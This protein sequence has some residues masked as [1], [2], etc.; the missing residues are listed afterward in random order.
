MR[1]IF[2]C[3]LFAFALSTS[4]QKIRFTDPSNGWVTHGSAP[5]CEFIGSYFYGADTIHH[6]IRYKKIISLFTSLLPTGC[7]TDDSSWWVRED[8]LLNRVYYRWMSWGSYD[9]VEHVLFEYNLS[10]GDT[11]RYISAFFPGFKDSVKRVDSVFIN[12]YAH[13]A[14]QINNWYDAREY[15]VVEGIGCLSGPLYTPRRTC[16]EFG[17]ELMCF[18]NRGTKPDFLVD[19]NGCWAADSFN[20]ISSCIKLSVANVSPGKEVNVYPNPAYETLNVSI[21]GYTD[22]PLS[23]VISDLLGHAVLRSDIQKNGK[24]QVSTSLLPPG[25]Y[26]L[27]F[28]NGLN[29]DKKVISVVH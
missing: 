17:E 26:I 5:E 21:E 8:T 28:G 6:G 19:N 29:T 4:A 20:N 27:T 11:F 10:A 24:V 7:G 3:I 25:T 18:F 2:T 16:F 14:L 15:T 22:F 1:L 13:K 23:L 12:G 9:T